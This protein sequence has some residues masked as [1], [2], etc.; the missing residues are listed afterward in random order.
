MR[1][2]CLLEQVGRRQKRVPGGCRVCGWELVGQ[3][4]LVEKGSC[5]EW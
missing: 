5:L 3:G 1:R 2:A 4:T